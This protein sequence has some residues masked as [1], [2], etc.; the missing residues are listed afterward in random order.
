MAICSRAIGSV[1][2]AI[3][4]SLGGV[5]RCVACM[6][7]G[8]QQEQQPNQQGYVHHFADLVDTKHPENPPKQ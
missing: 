5:A 3:Q 7:E 6:E 8:D 1:T 4:V 2:V